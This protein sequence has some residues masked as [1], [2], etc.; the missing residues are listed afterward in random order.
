MSWTSEELFESQ[1]QQ[2]IFLNFKSNQNGSGAHP[3]SHSMRSRG[4]FHME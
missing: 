2:K 4:Y 1:Q 3:S